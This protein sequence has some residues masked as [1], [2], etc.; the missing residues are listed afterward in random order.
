MKIDLK[1]NKIICIRIFLNSVLM[2]QLSFR[3][4]NIIKHLL[5]L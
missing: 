2:R 5:I 4:I 1:K 3:Q